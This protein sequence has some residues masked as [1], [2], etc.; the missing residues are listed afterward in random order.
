[1]A[2]GSFTPVGWQPTYKRFLGVR[3]QRINYLAKNGAGK[4]GG[5]GEEERNPSFPP[6]RPLS[7]FGSRPNFHAGKT[8]KNLFLDLSVP[9]STPQKRLLSQLVGS[10]P[11]FFSI[12]FLRQSVHDT[13]S[14][15]SV[16]AAETVCNLTAKLNT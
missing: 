12:I 5:G 13:E 3:E 14:R 6:P 7:C 9:F 15:G 16:C 8:P 2:S 10:T 4:R 11:I 1:M